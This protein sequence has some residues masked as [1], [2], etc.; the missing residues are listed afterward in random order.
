MSRNGENNGE[1][2]ERFLSEDTIRARVRELA[3]E[4]SRDYAGKEVTFLGT[5]NGA[6]YFFADLSRFVDIPVE[7]EFVK[8]S[9]YGNSTESS[10][11]V[12]FDYSP[13]SK[14]KGRHILWVED[15][16]DT[17]TTAVHLSEHI[18]KQ[19][20]ASLKLAALLD[21][22]DRR[23]HA[24]VAI[25]YL[26]FTIPDEFVVGYGLDY[27]GKYRNLPYIGILRFGL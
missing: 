16:V 27:A 22:P 25:D 1:T 6:V 7:A 5:L 13:G 9:S 2:V 17:G 14:L 12:R 15:I 3:G 18:M 20:P 11:L 24:G 10:R 4:I 23:L 8:V 26:G 19:E 21:K